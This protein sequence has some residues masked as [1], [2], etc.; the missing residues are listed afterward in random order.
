MGPDGLEVR[1][2]QGEERADVE[3][4][5]HTLNRLVA[6]LRVID[7]A[8]TASAI[9]PKWV[10]AGLSSEGR[11]LVA[12]VTARPDHRTKRSVQD[13]LM[14]VSALVRGVGLLAQEPE[15]PPFFV[16]SA[17]THLLEA[18]QPANGVQEVSLATFNGAVG[19]PAAVSEAVRTNAAAAVQSGY[20]TWGSVSGVLD[21]V[22]LRSKKS[23]KISVFDPATNRAV[24]GV[25][26]M[27]QG[28]EVHRTAREALGSRVLV[29]G[30]IYRNHRGQSIRVEVERIEVLGPADA[31]RLKWG[32]LLGAAPELLDGRSVDE[33]LDRVRSA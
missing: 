4:F 31:P 13:M 12:R 18:S 22:N 11:D 23:L 2:R 15:V 21:I 33:Y 9:R 5:T 32:D 20:A 7:G 26:S 14:P 19:P 1:I 24:S 17:V 6:T 16:E 28:P 29:G 3:R 10:V 30:R 25:I 27:D 8:Y